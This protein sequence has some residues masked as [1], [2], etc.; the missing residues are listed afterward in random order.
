MSKLTREE[1]EHAYDVQLDR[2]VNSLR[3]LADKVLYD[4]DARRARYVGISSERRA[5][6]RTFLASDVHDL[7][8]EWVGRRNSNLTCLMFAAIQAEHPTAR[9]TPAELLDQ[10]ATALDEALQPENGHIG[11]DA[12]EW[13]AEIALRCAGVI[14]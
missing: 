5:V 7:V 10:A 2:L 8:M 12:G 9:A 14:R 11:D 1:A 13:L 4:G 6:D 3:S